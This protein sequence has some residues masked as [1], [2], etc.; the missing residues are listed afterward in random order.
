MEFCTVTLTFES[1]DEI[2]WCDHSNESYWAV[3]SCG[4]VYYAVQGGSNFWVY[5]RNTMMWPFKWKLSACTYTWCYLSPTILEN[6]IWKFGR[7]LPLA[8]FGTERV[9]LSLGRRCNLT[10]VSNVCEAAPRSLFLAPTNSTNYRK[11][12]SKVFPFILIGKSTMAFFTR[13][14]RYTIQARSWSLSRDVFERCMSTGSEP[15]SLLM[16]LD[17]I[18]FVLLSLFTLKETICPRICSKSRPKSAKT[19][20]PVDVHCSKRLLLKLP[21]SAVSQTLL[22]GAGYVKSSRL[23]PPPSQL[24]NFSTLNT[25]LLDFVHFTVM[26]NT[27]LIT[28]GV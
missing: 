9:T 14:S 11:C 21:F 12:V 2:L 17:A 18:K 27:T 3:L 23:P 7:N 20:L 15:F 13:Q 6:E 26:R 8:T 16:C 4:T 28:L 19:P 5:G 25:C 1:M 22:I 24:M 10:P